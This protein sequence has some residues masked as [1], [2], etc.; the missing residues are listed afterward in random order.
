MKYTTAKIINPDFFKSFVAMLETKAGKESI[1]KLKWYSSLDGFDKDP[2]INAYRDGARD[3]IA[4]I[5]M[6]ADKEHLKSIT[7]RK[8]MYD[9]SRRTSKRKSG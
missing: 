5:E 1:K 9:E 4:L 3:I 7:K 8:E 6:W 2:Y